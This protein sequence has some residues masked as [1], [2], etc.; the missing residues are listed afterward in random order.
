VTAEP[1]QLL[2]KSSVY[3]RWLRYVIYNNLYYI[4]AHVMLGRK[5]SFERVG[6]WR[7]TVLLNHDFRVLGKTAFS[8]VGGRGPQVGRVAF[9][10]GRKK[11]L[12]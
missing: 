1:T 6:M 8:E 12:N 10:E 7:D 4:S 11:Q 9:P 2:L 3:L 5:R